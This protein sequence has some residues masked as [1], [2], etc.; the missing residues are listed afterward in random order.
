MSVRLAVVLVVLIV[1][2]AA[3]VGVQ[4]WTSN[5]RY[6]MQGDGIAVY[7]L[8]RKTGETTWI[9]RGEVKSRTW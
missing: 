7:V 4:L 5:L 9:V 3:V 2:V 6:E 8:D 1:A